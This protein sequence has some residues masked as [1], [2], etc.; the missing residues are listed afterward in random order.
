MK[1]NSGWLGQAKVIVIEATALI[2]LL[3]AAVALIM[4]EIRHLF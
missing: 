1:F 2:S 3:L 4:G